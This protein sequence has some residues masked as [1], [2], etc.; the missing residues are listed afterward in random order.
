M[1]KMKLKIPFE[2]IKTAV[3]QAS[4]GHH[5]LIDRK[6]HQIVFINEI[7]NDYEKKL[8]EVESDDFIDFELG[9][10]DDDF[11]IMESFIYGIQEEN[12]E[13][14]E[15][16]HVV[17]EQKKPFKHFKELIGKHP[18]LEEKWFK[19][20]D[21]ELTNE[22]MNWLCINNIELEDESFMPKIE[23][24]ELNAK[25]VK[26]PEEFEC[27]GPVECM[28]C[29]NN[30]GFKIRY[31][32]LSISNENMLIDKEIKRLMTEKYGIKDYGTIAGGDKEILTSSK[33]PKCDS[34]EIFE[35]F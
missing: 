5:Y 31:F 22:T 7:E 15:K 13:L 1:D 9:V 23:I 19:H 3:E 2:E 32:E 27:F 17:L 28:N 6:N 29:K 14:A 18:E 10:P 4:Y 34:S 21:K 11:L 35:D 25:E 26:L 20:K 8:A 12:F 33:C 16:F 24:R 30:A